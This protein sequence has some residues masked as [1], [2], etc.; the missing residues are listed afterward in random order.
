MPRA[1][2]EGVCVRIG[3]GDKGKGGDVGESDEANVGGEARVVGEIGEAR[4]EANVC[5]VG[6]GGGEFV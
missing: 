6:D 1:G 2:D 5:E 3:A 4:E